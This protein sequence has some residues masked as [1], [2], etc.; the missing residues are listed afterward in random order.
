MASRPKAK[1]PSDEP[2]NV[3]RN[4]NA[5]VRY[6]RAGDKFHYRWAARRCLRMIDPRSP[7]QCITIEG[8]KESKAAGE[9]VI[10]VAEY[11]HDG[12]GAEAVTAAAR[13]CARPPRKTLRSAG[14][15]TIPPEASPPSFAALAR[16]HPAANAPPRA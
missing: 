12:T 13:D 11:S 14:T 8:S 5:L 7:L 4:E 9:Y 10:D 3:T 2:Q 6:S 16:D 15:C 1:A